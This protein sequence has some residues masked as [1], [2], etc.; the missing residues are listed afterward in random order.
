MSKASHGPE[1]SAAWHSASQPSTGYSPE[2]DQSKH[3]NERDGAG[4]YSFSSVPSRRLYIYSLIKVSAK[5]RSLL[6]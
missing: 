3:H 6:L 2:D 5:D 4:Q 1:Y